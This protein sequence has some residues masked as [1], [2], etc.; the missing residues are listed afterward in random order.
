MAYTITK[1][2]SVF[3]NQAVVML[4]ITA[5]AATQTVD[6]GLGRIVAHSVG[7][8]SCSSGAIKIFA[9]KGAGGTATAGSIGISGCTSGDQFFVVCYGR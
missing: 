1:T 2:R 9:N 5:D 3:G 4:E 7:L 8:Q 6:V